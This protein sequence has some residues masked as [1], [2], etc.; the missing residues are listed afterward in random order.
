M[1]PL[2]YN[3]HVAADQL[4]SFPLPLSLSPVRLS[5][6]HIRDCTP[7]RLTLAAPSVRTDGGL[8]FATY[9]TQ[10]R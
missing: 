9:N 1:T 3:Y 4:V 6:Q 7:M 2:V 5:R 8:P 10:T